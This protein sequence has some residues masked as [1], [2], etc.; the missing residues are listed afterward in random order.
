[1]APTA[2]AKAD[3]A[4][5][6]IMEELRNGYDSLPHLHVV[7]VVSHPG[8][9]EFCIRAERSLA[10]LGT[11]AGTVTKIQ[12][13]ELVPSLFLGSLLLVNSW[14]VRKHLSLRNAILLGLGLILLSI[15]GMNLY[16]IAHGGLGYC[17]YPVAFHILKRVLVGTAVLIIIN[18][19]PAC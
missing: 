2:S 13:L 16:V 19:S 17:A 1:M 15:A 14:S 9:G 3:A 11:A 10:V 5:V 18:G 7:H 8:A 6:H 12:Y 4:P